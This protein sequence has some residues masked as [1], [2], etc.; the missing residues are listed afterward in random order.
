MAKKIDDLKARFGGGYPTEYEY[1]IQEIE[2]YGHVLKNV[3]IHHKLGADTIKKL[4]KEGFDI[5]FENNCY[6]ISG[7]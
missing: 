6:I 1:I 7:W 4:K 3:I 5:G 2:K